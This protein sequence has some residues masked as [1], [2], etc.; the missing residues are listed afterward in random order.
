MKRDFQV[1]LWQCTYK[2]LHED[3]PKGYKLTMDDLPMWCHRYIKHR[4]QLY[5]RTGN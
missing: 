1:L 5:D 3:K 2:K 4:F